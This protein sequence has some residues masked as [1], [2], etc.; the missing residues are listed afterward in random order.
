MNW[1]WLSRDKLMGMTLGVLLMPLI[2]QA[3]PFFTVGVLQSLQER[4][5]F[6]MI[7]QRI[8]VVRE[9]ARSVPCPAPVA[10][11]SIIQQILEWDGRIAHEQEANRHWYSDYFSTD[12]WNEVRPIALP[13]G[14]TS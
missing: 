4:L 7:M 13:C 3:A 10:D 12:R 8:E 6:P 2:Q 1:N 14:G 5:T 11:Q 9:A